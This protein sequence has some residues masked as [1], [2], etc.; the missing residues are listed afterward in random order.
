MQSAWVCWKC[1]A[2]LDDLPLPLSRRAQCPACHAELHVCRMCRH[3]DTAKAKQCR[4]TA[5]E[6]VLDKDRANFCEWFQARPAAY[7]TPGHS[8]AAASRAELEALFGGGAQSTS[9][10]TGEAA[11]RALDDLFGEDE[12]SHS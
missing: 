10:R 3:Y 9:P 7:A 5:A 11:R 1:G 6:E 2:G 12:R 4:E 8:D